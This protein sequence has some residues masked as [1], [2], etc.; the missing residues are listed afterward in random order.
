MSAVAAAVDRW[1]E[2]EAC[3][4]LALESPHGSVFCRP[5]FLDALD[6]PWE[7]WGGPPGAGGFAALLF[8]EADGSVARGPLPFT[9]YQGL[10]GPPESDPVPSHRRIRAHLDGVAA[11]LDGLASQGALSF[12]LHPRFDDLRP[13]SWFN[14]DRPDQ[15]AFAIEVR[16]TGLIELDPARGIEGLLADSRAARRQE[17]RKASSRFEVRASVDLE[18]LDELHDRTFRRQGIGRPERQRALLR[19]IAA[20]ALRSGFGELL[21]AWTPDGRPASAVLAL[22]DQ[23]S[24]YYLVA[25]NDPEFRASG[26]STLL[27]VAAADRCLARG[28]TTLDVVGMNSPGRGDFKASFGARAVPYYQAHWCRP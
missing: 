5:D 7:L 25:A 15:G 13:L 22:F 14:Y 17:Y 12:C 24:G 8:R 9:M 1:T 2:R 26:S 3:D 21:V 16:Y 11:L 19:S 10:L 27:F 20:A 6:R 18:L 4:R 23:C 28:V